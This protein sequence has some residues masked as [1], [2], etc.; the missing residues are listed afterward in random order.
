MDTDAV[1][2]FIKQCWQTTPKQYSII[3]TQNQKRSKHPNSQYQGQS[4][5]KTSQVLNI[6]QRMLLCLH[7]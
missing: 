6:D 1:G 2:C 4:I 7:V 3:G 5:V